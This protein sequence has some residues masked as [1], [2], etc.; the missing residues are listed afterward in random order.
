M[1]SLFVIN[2]I[3]KKKGDISFY[4]DEKNFDLRGWDLLSPNNSLINFKILNDVKNLDIKEGFF[5]I[6]KIA[7]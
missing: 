7:N 5:D 6:P 2:Y 3:F 1:N 4:F